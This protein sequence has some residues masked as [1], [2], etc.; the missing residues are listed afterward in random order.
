MPL[1][2]V[3]RPTRTWMKFH[4]GHIFHENSFRE[5]ANECEHK[6]WIYSQKILDI[7]IGP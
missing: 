6:S 2:S 1:Y 7:P 3:L 4:V 5:D